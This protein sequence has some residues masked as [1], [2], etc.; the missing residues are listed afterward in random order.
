MK[1]L[2]DT[3][4]EIKEREKKQDK[5]FDEYM[6][7]VA[8]SSYIPILENSE[9]T[10]FLKGIEYYNK[11]LSDLLSRW[12]YDTNEDWIITLESWKE[13]KINNK[14]TLITYINENLWKK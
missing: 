11:E 7:V 2:I 6:K 14:E 5:A 8:P 12:I 9:I 4:F 13:Y 10:A 1:K 3:F